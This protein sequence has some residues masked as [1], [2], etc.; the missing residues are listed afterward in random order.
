MPGDPSS[1]EVQ[2]TALLKADDGS[3]DIDASIAQAAKQ[4]AAGAT[5]VRFGGS[6][7]DDPQQAAD[8]FTELVGAYRERAAN[9][10][11]RL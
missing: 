6:L 9:S 5:D 4:V 11:P 7:P 1:L 2:G 8:E 3:L 10:A